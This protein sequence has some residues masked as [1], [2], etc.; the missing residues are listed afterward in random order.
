KAP[1]GVRARLQQH[2][3]ARKWSRALLIRRATL[4]GLT[5]AHAGWLE[6]DLYELFSAAENANLHN[7]QVPGDDTVPSYDLRTLESFRDPIV[8]VLRL[9][10]Y[11]T[12]SVDTDST[13]GAS[14]RRTKTHYGDTVADLIAAGLVAGGDRLVSVNGSWPASAAVKG[15]GSISYNDQN[16]PSPS[17]A[18]GAVKGGSA[19]GWDFWAVERAGRSVRLS[20]LRERYRKERK[21]GDADA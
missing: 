19:N 15:D 16:Y 12:E 2:G 4:H 6:G 17:S 10:G 3:R 20:A 18:A 21:G 11:E 14:P 8:R 7:T 9:L 5:S 1:A 13:A